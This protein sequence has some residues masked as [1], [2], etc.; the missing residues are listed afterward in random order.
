MHSKHIGNFC[1]T[2]LLQFNF[3]FL[4][5]KV[6][7]KNMI[8]DLNHPI[9]FAETNRTPWVLFSQDFM[10]PNE[11]FENSQTSPTF[12]KS[13]LILPCS[14][15][16]KYTVSSK[17]FLCPFRHANVCSQTQLKP[18]DLYEHLTQQ[19]KFY[20]DLDLRDC[21]CTAQKKKSCLL[22]RIFWLSPDHHEVIVKK[23][24]LHT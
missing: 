19:D 18:G 21:G 7:Q 15:A 4:I 17:H 24:P 3:S 8:A 14:I 11:V 6:L 2:L 9:S 1:I 10:D 20:T 16:R 13:S 5:V 23:N 22:K 12:Q